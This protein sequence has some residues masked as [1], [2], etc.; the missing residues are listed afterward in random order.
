M[1]GHQL[2]F[3]FRGE[4]RP[5]HRDG[6]LVEFAGKGERRPVIRV[7][8]AGQ[9]IRADVKA[10]VPL[11]DHWQGLFH[12]P[13]GD[14]DAVDL[15]GAGAGAAKTT[16]IVEGKGADAQTVVFEVK[17]DRVLAGL[18]RLRA[19]PLDAL[20]IYHVPQE[21]RFALEQVES[22]TGEASARCEDH[23][24]GTALGDS[25]LRRNGIRAVEQERGIALR[26]TNHRMGVNKLRAAGGNVWTRGHD[27]GRHRGI[28]REDLIFLRLR[29]EL[30]AQLRDLLRMLCGDV[31]GLGE[32]GGQ[33]IELE[34]LVVERIRVGRAESLPG[35]AVDLGAEQPAVVVERPLTHH[36]EVLGGVA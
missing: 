11:Q 2:L 27:A 14:F 7:V 9:R 16:H 31:I 36:L 8:H 32:V 21:H 29:K 13:G 30:L 20:Q 6:E 17:L 33:V 22:I 28:Q 25:D 15:E 18:K 3:I 24:L 10:F 12:F 5:V 19:F 1:G 26:Q 23:A 34:H 35:R 4:F